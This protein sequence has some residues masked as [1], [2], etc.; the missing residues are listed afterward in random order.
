M[1]EGCTQPLSSD[2]M[3]HLNTTGFFLIVDVP[4]VRNLHKLESLTLTI[5]ISM[6]TTRVS[7]WGEGEHASLRST[8]SSSH[9][10]DEG[11]IHRTRQNKP[12]APTE[13][14]P[15][16][17]PS[18]SCCKMKALPKSKIL[19]HHRRKER[20]MWN[21]AHGD[22][23]REDKRDKGYVCNIVVTPG[24]RRQTECEPCTCQDQ[25]FTYTAVT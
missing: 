6:K 2:P 21:S 18:L 19:P 20:P 16:W 1:D 10:T 11:H 12:K 9:R 14:R 4:F 22:G 23:P 8:T 15:V 17:S 24:F 13:R 25:L 5:L 7:C 3:I